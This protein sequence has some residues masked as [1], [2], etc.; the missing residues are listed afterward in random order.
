MATILETDEN[1]ALVLPAR[2]L[3]HDAAHARYVV[4]AQGETLVLRPDVE[5]TKP[6]KTHIRK[7]PT[8][9]EWI[10]E[11]RELGEK[12]SEAWIGDKSAVEELSDMRNARG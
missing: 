6:R 5:A 1:G 2:V 9:D 12:I 11:W 4:E 7:K 10:K 3:G 8:P